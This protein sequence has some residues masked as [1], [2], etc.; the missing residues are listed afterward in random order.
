MSNSVFAWWSLK[1]KNFWC[2]MH[3][4][5]FFAKIEKF[6][7]KPIL[8]RHGSNQDCCY[9][10]SHHYMS[11]SPWIFYWTIVIFF[12]DFLWF[13]EKKYSSDFLDTSDQDHLT[14]SHLRHKKN[15]C[16]KIVSTIN[17]LDTAY[18]TAKVW[19]VGIW[20]HFKKHNYHFHHTICMWTTL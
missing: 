18:L 6:V 10:F 3:V 2:D 5:F 8:V 11:L 7:Y 4:N 17:A 14:V 9:V 1:H 13:L 15:W 16:V 19:A 20:T 12:V